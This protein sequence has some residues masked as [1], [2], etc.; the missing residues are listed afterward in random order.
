VSRSHFASGGIDLTQIKS[1]EEKEATKHADTAVTP[2][3]CREYCLHPEH[4][5]TFTACYSYSPFI[6]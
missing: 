5:L 2:V 4:P 3:L 1:F 6:F